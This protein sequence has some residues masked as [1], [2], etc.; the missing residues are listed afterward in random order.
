MAIAVA[1]CHCATY[2]TTF[3]FPPLSS[4]H[5]PLNPQFR[6]KITLKPCCCCC[7]AF[8]SRLRGRKG[9]RPSRACQSARGTPDGSCGE[10]NNSQL[11]TQPEPIPSG[12]RSFSVESSYKRERRAGTIRHNRTVAECIYKPW[13]SSSQTNVTNLYDDA[14]AAASSSVLGWPSCSPPRFLRR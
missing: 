3:P 8:Y 2:T 12:P 5:V 10:V 9:Y 11:G 4:S 13:R 1:S 7:F 14:V 6:H